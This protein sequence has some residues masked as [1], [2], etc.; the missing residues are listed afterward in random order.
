MA[1]AVVLLRGI[2]LG[3]HNR[4]AMPALREALAGDG[5]KNPRTYA[6][7]G[8]I[9]LE[10]DLDGSVLEDRVVG[11]ITEQ[12]S[13]VVRA[14]AMSDGELA[15]VVAGNPFPQLAAQDPKRFQVTFLRDRP[16][17]GVADGP[18]NVPGPEPGPAG[19]AGRLSA[20]ATPNERVAVG[21]REVY[22]W[23]PDG[24]ARSKL[25]IKLGGR[26]GVGKD[27]V[28]TSRNWT[29]VLTLLNMLGVSDAG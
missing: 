26:T 14:V 18:G 13:L 23:H 20:L 1:T 7:S 16:D 15:R 5:F 8:N 4:I 29:T 27:V 6:Q 21:E 28:A 17:A 22:S 25:A 2:N 10:T 11:L 19:L 9:V 12:F 3:P 24:V